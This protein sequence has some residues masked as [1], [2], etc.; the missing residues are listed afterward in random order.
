MKKFIGLLILIC[1]PAFLTMGC[2][3]QKKENTLDF[4]VIDRTKVFMESGL[5]QTGF[6]RIK[7]L[8]SMA[9]ESLYAL[10]AKI[11]ALDEPMEEKTLR[12]QVEL[13]GGLHSLQ[14]LID[15]DQELVIS[16]IEKTLDETIAQIRAEKKI[17]LVFASE[18]VLSYDEKN[19]ITNDVIQSLNAQNVVFPELPDVTLPDPAQKEKKEEKTVEKK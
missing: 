17:P 2:D 10:E 12:M 3:L 19:D 15:A 13:Q 18:T 9:E 8:Q 16:L 1:A 5:G 7:Q 6:D 14:A 11:N 4:A